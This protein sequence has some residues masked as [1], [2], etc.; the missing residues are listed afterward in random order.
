MAQRESGYTTAIA[1]TS[2]SG[3]TAKAKAWHQN[4]QR[5]MVFDPRGEWIDQRV[6]V[7]RGDR[8]ALNDLSL[9]SGPG[10]FAFIPGED[11]VGDF[12]LFCRVAY[13]WV[14]V[15]PGAVVVDELAQFTNAGKAIGPWGTLTRMG[16]HYGAH[17]TGITQFP[18]ESDRTIW[19]NADR[20]VAFLMEGD[21]DQRTLARA[22]SVRVDQ[23]PTSRFCYLV[24]LTGD[25]N[26]VM[27]GPDGEPLQNPA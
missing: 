25:P 13:S 26:P 2:Q 17:I 14:Q 8:L 21:D 5:M 10:R 20:K 3:K 6:E 18:T 16:K 7:I 19:R 22:L 4:V 15:W 1:G 11:I 24:K 27:Y 23:L 9:A 12:E